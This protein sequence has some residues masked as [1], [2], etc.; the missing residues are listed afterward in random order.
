M[1]RPSAAV[2]DLL[3]AAVLVA[4]TQVEVWA[5]HDRTEGPLP[6]QHLAFLLM[7]GA[8][9]FRRTAPLVAT[10]ICS[11]GLG[12]QTALGEAPVVGGFVAMLVV[13]VS[14]GYYASLRIGLVGLG[15]ML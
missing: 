13:L 6:W 10:L 14:L 2:G 8:V 15:A 1:R 12:L 4:A 5:A 7:T 11:V 9:A 3:V